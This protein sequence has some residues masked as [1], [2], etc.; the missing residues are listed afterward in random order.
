MNTEENKNVASLSI[1]SYDERLKKY[2]K[3][4]EKKNVNLP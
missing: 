1:K 4:L 3:D 2:A